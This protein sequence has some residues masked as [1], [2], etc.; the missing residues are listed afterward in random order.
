MAGL[1]SSQYRKSLKLLDK[2]FGLP[3]LIRFVLF[4][5]ASNS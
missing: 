3:V 2:E 1:G 5:N 4:D